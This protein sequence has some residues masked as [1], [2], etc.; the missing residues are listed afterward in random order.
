MLREEMADVTLDH[1][2]RTA[3]IER[4]TF[5][6]AG[7][8]RELTCGYERAQGARTAFLRKPAPGSYGRCGYRLLSQRKTPR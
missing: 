5:D 1:D 3:E 4:K 7:P 2:T 8:G 6:Q